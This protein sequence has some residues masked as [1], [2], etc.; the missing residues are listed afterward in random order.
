MS[1]QKKP[2]FRKRSSKSFP[3]TFQKLLLHVAHT[4]KHVDIN[5]LGNKRS[6]YTSFRARV[7]EYRSAF[8]NE[9]ILEQDELKI[10]LADDMYCVTLQNPQQ[11]ENGQW[12][13]RVKV[14]DDRFGEAIAE[15]LG[16]EAGPIG[17]FNVSDTPR[18]PPM[19]KLQSADDSGDEGMKAIQDL[20]T[21]DEDD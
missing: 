11:D 10:R 17:E 3:P 5:N 2:F 6:Y 19:P 8:R 16:D 15:K 7:N 18:I 13:C 12:F 4:G 14:F 1:D 9:A 21:G 20:Y